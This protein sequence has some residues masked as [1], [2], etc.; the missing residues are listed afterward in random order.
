MLQNI[1]T[2][3]AIDP[4]LSVTSAQQEKLIYSIPKGSESN[5]FAH[6]TSNSYSAAGVSWAVNTQSSTALMDRRVY[7]SI[8]Y[9]VTVTGLMPIG[10]RMLNSGYVAP[11]SFP[12]NS[13]TQNATATIGGITL[14]SKPQE[15]I[16][17]LM[18][19]NTKS[20]GVNLLG[21][22]LSLCP[23]KL[24]NVQI[25]N[26]IMNGMGLSI[27]NVLADFQSSGGDVL[28]R[29]AFFMDVQT[30]PVSVDPAVPIS[31]TMKFTSIEP[32]FI[33]P[34]MYNT[35]ELDSAFIGLQ[36]LSI[37]LNFDSN[38][39]RIISLAE[40]PGQTVQSVTATLGSGITDNPVLHIQYLNPPQSLI[41]I[42]R[43]IYYPYSRI[44]SFITANS[45]VMGHGSTSTFT[46]DTIQLSTIPKYIYIGVRRRMT[47]STY[48]HC[49]SFLPI[50]SLTVNY[51]T[52]S[53]QFS[54][55]RQVDLYNM[56]LKNGLQMSFTE[57][58]GF[59]QNYGG[60][61]FGLSSAPICISSDDLSLGENIAQGMDNKSSF[62]YQITV[63]NSN[64]VDAMLVDLVAIF[65]NDGIFTIYDGKAQTS[66]ELITPEI[67]NST[68]KSGKTII[69]DNS[70]GGNIGTIYG[71]TKSF[72][73]N[74]CSSAEKAYPLIEKYSGYSGS[75]F[76]E[77]LQYARGGKADKSIARA[78]MMLARS[79]LKENT[80]TEWQ[81]WLDLQDPDAVAAYKAAKAARSAKAAK[82]AKVAS[83]RPPRCDIGTERRCP[84][85][86]TCQDH[87][88][89][90]TRKNKA[91]V[92][93][94]TQINASGMALMNREQLLNALSQ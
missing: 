41:S 83:T 38:L 16:Q 15:T 94:K 37:S 70:Q 47:A 75:G 82:S 50:S 86:R 46:S 12:T 58:K 67:L 3:N 27:N 19:Y 69:A 65:V 40:M 14:S 91:K 17:S 39:S 85:A 44:E 31:A 33:S 93:K 42:K 34:F 51:L 76:A 11:R 55:M 84:V 61:Q 79:D 35:Q 77:G 74:V 57:F 60:Y 20:G 90:T 23:S 8:Q 5:N 63:T 59:T 22:D 25:Y 7:S 32:L 78:V 72:L 29:G 88:R 24:D 28:G 2:V 6:P 21:Y 10:G 92:E 49:D 89:I 68:R 73:K 4:R 18:R 26:S 52:V 1:K 53:G 81:D 48:E 45:T 66:T 64:Q 9:L 71:K 43:P 56:S 87:G 62:T 54:S 30:N 13:I 36:N 80:E